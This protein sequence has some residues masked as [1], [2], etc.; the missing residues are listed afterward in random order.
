MPRHRPP[1]ASIT[2]DGAGLFAFPIAPAATS[3]ADP[4]PSNGPRPRRPAVP[5][6][7]IG[8]WYQDSDSGDS[9]SRG[10]S[11]QPIFSFPATN[12]SSSPS[13]PSPLPKDLPPKST[14]GFYKNSSS[15]AHAR[16]ATVSAK[17]NWRDKGQ[18][19]AAL[20][21]QA[22]GKGGD[23]MRVSQIAA[24]AGTLAVVIMIVVLMSTSKSP[25]VKHMERREQEL[26]AALRPSVAHSQTVPRVAREHASFR[27]ELSTDMKYL[28]SP[29]HGNLAE[30]VMN[31]YHL[32]HLSTVLQRIPIATP[33]SVTTTED[34]LTKALVPVSSLFDMARFSHA[35]SVAVLD[36]Q[37]LRPDPEAKK[38]EQL[39]CWIGKLGEPEVQQ[40]AESMWR[41]G[42]EASFVPVRVSTSRTRQGVPTG[43]ELLATHEFISNFDH[44]ASAQAGL[45]E[46]ARHDSSISTATHSRHANPED[47]VFC[48][49]H[50]LY[51][52]EHPT[53][54]HSTT[55]LDPRDHTAFFSHGQHLHFAPDINKMAA[56][57]VAHLLGHRQPFLAVHISAEARAA[58]CH[59]LSELDKCFPEVATY[60]HAIGRLKHLTSISQGSSHRK[61]REHR[62][63]A[64]TLSVVVSTDVKDL[65]F[66]GEL[67][68]LGWTVLDYDDLE[69]KERFGTWSPE[70]LT[71]AIESRAAGF[72]GTRGS[73][74]STLSALR[75]RAWHKGPT[76]LV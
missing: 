66:L 27:D 59:L 40:R 21:K 75:V 17:L 14:G 20:R 19:Y 34:S 41:S 13:L 18:D 24:G 7:E 4:L 54:Q 42:I 69:L 37:D 72:V 64:R 31:L 47:H 9:S 68:H 3:T 16:K 61:S 73:P 26:A 67:S 11:P 25:S 2:L 46:Q 58:E 28:T 22:L 56:D 51:R 76:E 60:Q 52:P 74:Q 30:Q 8:V 62:H 32:A 53:T 44:D 35:S 38:T 63:S 1:T 71:Q 48:I 43:D 36:W 49:D 6:P 70:V 39:G 50:S 23:G 65:A 55:H 15:I 57:V 12:T 10:I 5:S 45:I 33:F 29:Q